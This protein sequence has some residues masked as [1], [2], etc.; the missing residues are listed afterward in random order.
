[1]ARLYNQ[2]QA[3]SLAAIVYSSLDTL[4]PRALQQPNI[5]STYGYLP[6]F[7]MPAENIFKGHLYLTL[8]GVANWDSDATALPAPPDINSA[9]SYTGDLALLNNFSA[10]GLHV[11]DLL[12]PAVGDWSLYD[13]NAVDSR[14][15]PYF[16]RFCSDPGKRSVL[17]E[18]VARAPTFLM[19]WIGMDQI[20][21]YAI[22]GGDNQS[23]QSADGFEANLRQVIKQV[24]TSNPQMRG[25]IG[26]IAPIL[27]SLPF[28]NFFSF[29][30]A[31]FS[32]DDKVALEKH[33]MLHTTAN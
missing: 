12:D 31:L 14:L 7:S 17:D 11:Q 8:I 16:A 27:T 19:L 18:V 23:L 26:D 13:A 3:Q 5:G 20:L 1:M 2:S 15:N 33:N 10:P 22:N 4:A 29:D 32:P 25:V 21:D 24:S 9:F 30:E 28:F 6:E